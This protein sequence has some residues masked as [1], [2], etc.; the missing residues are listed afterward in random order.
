MRENIKKLSK[1]VEQG[2]DESIPGPTREEVVKFFAEH[3]DPD[4]SVLHKWAED[5]RFDVPEVEN[6]AYK[7]VT[8]YVSFLTTGKAVLEKYT[9]EMV[10]SD[11]MKLGMGVEAEHG[12]SPKLQGRIVLD[13][14]AEFKDPEILKEYYKRLIALEKE[15]MDKAK[16]KAKI[17]AATV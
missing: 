2:A 11:V 14:G 6:E 15:L 8:E 12:D 1:F 4:D 5:N 10:P 13:H 16:A 7:L 9:A 3:P 17:P